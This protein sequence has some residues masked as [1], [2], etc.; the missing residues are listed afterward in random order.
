MTIQTIRVF[1]ALG[2]PFAIT[3]EDGEKVF[4]KINPILQQQE[5]VALDFTHIELVVSTFLNASVGQLYGVYDDDFI[6][7]HFSVTNMSPDD[8]EILAK[9]IKTA[10]DFFSDKK[11]FTDILKDHFS[12]DE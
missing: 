3:T 11:G 9:V 6:E 2:S 8:R 1:D 4:G 12:D 5:G 10:K 7:A